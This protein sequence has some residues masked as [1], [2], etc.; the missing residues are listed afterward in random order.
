[1]EFKEFKNLLFAKAL[2]A[3]FDECEIYYSKGESIS[4]T[5]YEEEVEKYNLDKSFGLSFRGKIDDKMGYSFTEILDEEAVTMLVKNAKDAASVIE[6]DSI[7]FIYEGDKVYNEVN[8]YSLE[9]ENIDAGKLIKLAIDMEKEAKNYSD[10]VVNIS[11]CKISYSSSDYGL[12]NTKGLELNNKDNLLLAYVAP[13]VEGNNEKYDGMGYITALSL[14]EINPKEIAKQGVEDALSKIGGQSIPSGKYKTI[15]YNDAM[16]SLMDTFSEVFSGDTA[17]KGLSLLKGKEGK[18]IAAPIVTIV[19]DPLLDNGLASTPFDDEGVATFKKEVVS[20]GVLNTLLH[21]LK[22]SHKAGTK[23]TGNGFKDSYA[24]TVKVSPTNF[25]IK[26]GDK[27]LDELIS[28][29]GEGLIVTDF[30]G[31][32]SGASAITGDFSLAAKG[33]YV[34]DGKRSYPV[35][36]ITIAGNFF[37][38]LKDIEIIGDDLKFPL[39]SVGSPSVV[40]KGLSVAGK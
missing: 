37:E 36:Q 10:K 35:E 32:H 39:N 34:K 3:G 6:N 31:L 13:V 4:I 23:T 14:D 2:E 20:K 27:S 25:Y 28:Y 5:V 12:S 7:E 29:I 9:L 30:A 15:I 33:F 40:V 38:L 1:M 26:K 16:V 24:S 18:V 17:Q 19:D 8:T 21:N 22:T 11:G